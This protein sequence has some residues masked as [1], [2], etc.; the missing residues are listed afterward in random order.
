MAQDAMSRLPIY[1]RV[2]KATYLV[3]QTLLNNYLVLAAV[4]ALV[5]ILFFNF[6]RNKQYLINASV[7]FVGGVATIYALILSTEGQQGG[8]TYF[9]GIIFLIMCIIEILPDQ[10]SD[11]EKIG[12]VSVQI[13]VVLLVLSAS[14][15][16]FNGLV[17]SIKSANAIEA[18][19]SYIEKNIDKQKKIIEVPILNYYPKTSYS[20]N[21]GLMDVGKDAYAF[22]NKGYHQYFYDKFKKNIR[23]ILKD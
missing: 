3:T 14:K 15:L 22:P 9:G 7:W 19:Y 2:I 16:I 18:R 23:V 12:K 4:I 8:R 20:I 11:V 21:H 10:Y 13:L 17:D 1:V 5:F 6:W